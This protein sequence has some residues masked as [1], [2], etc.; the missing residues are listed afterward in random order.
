MDLGTSSKFSLTEH[1]KIVLITEVDSVYL[2]GT[3]SPY[4][5]QIS[6]VFKLLT[7]VV[8]SKSFRPDQLFKV[9]QLSYFSIQ[10]P[11]ISTHFLHL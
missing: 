4:I 9:N 2:R 8:G 7:Y 1:Y 3:Q 6:L 11:F 10:S 5:T